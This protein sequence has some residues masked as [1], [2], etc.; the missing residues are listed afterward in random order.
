L[1]LLSDP[2]GTESYN[3]QIIQENK[4]PRRINRQIGGTPKRQTRPETPSNTS[5]VT[6]IDRCRVLGL[7]LCHDDEIINPK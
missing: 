3:V 1:D 7:A 2:S 6:E 4:N 5:Q